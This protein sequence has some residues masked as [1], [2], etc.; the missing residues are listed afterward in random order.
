MIWQSIASEH[1]VNVHCYIQGKSPPLSCED[2]PLTNGCTRQW[3][4]LYAPL[5][6]PAEHWN[7]LKHHPAVVAQTPPAATQSSIHKVA[8]EIFLV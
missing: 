1:S 2:K 8:D 6:L 7:G 4:A 3:T 5:Q